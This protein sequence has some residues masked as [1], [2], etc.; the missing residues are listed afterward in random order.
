MGVIPSGHYR[1]LIVFPYF[2]DEVFF[3]CPG[4]DSFF[5]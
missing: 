4:I 1:V 5:L 3:I 2:S